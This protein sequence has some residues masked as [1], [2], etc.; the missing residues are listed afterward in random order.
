M[1]STLSFLTS[2]ALV[3]LVGCTTD[4][5]LVENNNP[6]FT[7]VANRADADKLFIVDCL[8]PGQIRKLGSKMTYLSPRR[9]IKASAVECEI[10][11]GEYVAFDRANYAT[12]LRIWLP[13][14]QEGDPEAQVY[15]GEIYEKGLGVAPDYQ[16][17]AGWYRKAAAQGSSRAQINLGYLYEKGMGV[18][19]NMSVAMEWYRK[20]SGLEQKE[21]PYSATLKTSTESEL[22]EE[23]KLLKNE[24]KNSRKV[25]K[26]LERQLA[27]KQRQLQESLEK[28]K[29]IQNERDNTQ[30]KLN[31]AEAGGNVSE[32][33]RLKKVL[34]EKEQALN[35]QQSYVTSLKSQYQKQVD[36]LKGELKETE[37]HAEQIYGQ[38]QTQKSATDDAQLK[39]LNAE[40]QLANTEQKLLAAQEKFN[41]LQTATETK[42]QANAKTSTVDMDR[43]QRE[44]MERMQQEL[45]KSEQERREAQAA[46]ERLASEKRLYEEKVKQLQKKFGAADEANK[47]LTAAE[48]QL[49]KTDQE[50]YIAQQNYNALQAELK[51]TK[52]MYSQ[53]SQQAIAEIERQHQE[54]LDRLQ[55]DLTKSEQQRKEAVS[56]LD[57]LT[58]EKQRVEEQIKQQQSTSS[59]VNEVNEQLMNAEAQLK[60]TEEALYKAQQDY[61]RLQA[62]LKA[63][64]TQDIRKPSVS[65]SGQQG[66]LEQVRQELAKSEEEKQE[67]LSIV[68]QLQDEKRQYELQIKQL[69]KDASSADKSDKPVIEIIDPPFVV[70]RGMPTVKLRSAVKERA[71]I[72][73]ATSNAGILSVMVNDAKNTVDDRGIFNANVAVT[74]SKTP[75]RVVAIDRNGMRE[76]L[77]FLL[78]YD[79][80]RAEYPYQERINSSWFKFGYPLG[81]VT[82]VLLNLEALTEAGVVDDPRLNDAV[83]LL[84]SKQDE[85]GRWKLEYSYHGKMWIDVEKKGQPSKWV[86]LRALRVLMDKSIRRRLIRVM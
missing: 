69:Q 59:G 43:R 5:A 63:V 57:R 65:V 52:A 15:T 20:A 47:Q 38:L 45:A 67:A 40:K 21:I 84:L 10:R 77:D 6:D 9:P 41:S 35:S 25:A 64:R 54:K 70:M 26:A 22:A 53:N 60:E 75:V 74:G 68:S 58:L 4:P 18:E 33:T 19:K 13:K 23:V 50:L 76:S 61:D 24:L 55:K 36:E 14:A 16:T 42:A 51:A 48:S 81:Y 79:I 44:K 78:S 7:A 85:Q 8:L 86:T 39:L 49:K 62:E 11:G 37:K 27:D 12:A 72:G 71:I 73:K 46:L 28:L 17:A 56:A 1:K 3:V 82:D 80:A 34:Q 30:S 31:D 83:A 32:S 66:G 2:L 29:R